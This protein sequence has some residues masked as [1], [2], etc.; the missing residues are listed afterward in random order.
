MPSGSTASVPVTLTRVGEWVLAEEVWKEG[1]WVDNDR[2]VLVPDGARITMRHNFI[3]PPW[4]WEVGLGPGQHN[5]Y[6]ADGWNKFQLRLD[7]PAGR[8]VV[9]SWIL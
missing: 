3:W 4:H 9:C 7:S 1:F 8:I 2:G 5:F 6:I